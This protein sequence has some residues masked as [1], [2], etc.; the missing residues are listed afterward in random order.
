MENFMLQSTVN[1]AQLNHPRTVHV[2][3]ASEEPP[4][5]PMDLQ[6]YEYS[7][8]YVA[9]IPSP[10]PAGEQN[11]EDILNGGASEP[12][13]PQASTPRTP[14]RKPRTIRTSTKGKEKA[15]TQE[16]EHIV[17]RQDGLKCLSEHHEDHRKRHGVRTGALD[18]QAKEKAR[19]IRKIKACWNCWVQKVP[20]S[21]GGG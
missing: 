9:F 8:G 1:Q 15:V 20:V 6:V 2:Q 21:W 19:K 10:G 7:P 13:L 11:A 12:P 5:N 3:T 14:E 16:W 18:P 4:W 17:I